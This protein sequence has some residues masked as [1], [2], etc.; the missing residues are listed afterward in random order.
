[1]QNL[2]A[3][4]RG[5]CDTS[6]AVVFHQDRATITGTWLKNLL[7]TPALALSSSLFHQYQG[8]GDKGPLKIAVEK[9]KRTVETAKGDK[10]QALPVRFGV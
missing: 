1:M 3:R 10:Y 2:L 8:R 6:M 7:T 4:D 5:E 9:H